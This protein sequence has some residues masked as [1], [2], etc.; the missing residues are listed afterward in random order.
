MELVEI[1]R[2]AGER[3]TLVAFLDYYRAVVW[4]KAEGLDAEALNRRLGPS[5]LTLGGLLK[6]LAYVEDVW[7]DYRLAGHE[8]REPWRS[9]DWDADA[10]WELTSAAG[11]EPAY[12][13]ELYGAAI[14]RSRAILAEVSDLGLPLRRDPD[15]SARWM[16][17][18]LVEEYAR[19][20][21]H[22]DLLREAIDGRVGD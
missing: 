3:E 17:V 6:H 19:H 18:H 10:D 1:P 15:T 5:T 8:P 12:L 13:R 16:L 14:Q 4:R 20:A 22:A 2:L 9:A 11:D 7:I 21:G